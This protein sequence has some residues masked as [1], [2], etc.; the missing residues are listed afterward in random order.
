MTTSG[1]SSEIYW[2]LIEQ[3]Q[4]DADKKLIKIIADICTTATAKAKSN[5]EETNF[6]AIFIRLLLTELPIK[7]KECSVKCHNHY[8]TK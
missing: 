6:I 8:D 1:L 7:Y 3:A 4:E 5:K 2:S